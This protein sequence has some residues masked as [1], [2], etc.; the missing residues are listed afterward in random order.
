MSIDLG[1]AIG[2]LDLDTSGFTSGF[3][4]AKK[5][6]KTFSD[7]STTLNDKISASGKIMSTVGGTLT[8]YVTT[9]LLGAGTA[10]IG[11][12]TSVDKAFNQFQGRV[13]D[14]VKD[15][16][17]YRNVMSDIYANNFG[18]SIEDVANSMADVVTYLGEMPVDKMQS[19]TESAITLRNTFGYETAESLRTVDT[20]MKNFGLSAEEAFD[21]IVTGTQEGL[22]F[23]GEF[24]DTINEYSVQFDKLGFSAEDMFAILKQGADSGAWNL[25][26]I[27][28][29][30]KE[31]SIRAVDGSNT[32]IQGFELLGFSAEDM[33]SKFAQGGDTAKT[34]FREIINALADMEDP[35]QQN[36]AGV[37]LFGTM[38]EDLG[39]EV[40]TQLADITD[41]AMVTT[42]AM[43]QLKEVKYDDLGSALEGLWRTFQVLVGELGESLIPKV[44]SVIE[45]LQ[46]LIDKFRGMDDS[47]KET[48]VNVGLFV[49]ALGPVLTI[50]GKLISGVSSLVS[51]ISTAVAAVGGWGAAL[52]ALTGPIGIVIAAVAA[53]AAAWA[54]D[55]AGIRETVQSVMTSIQEIISSVWEAI[56]DLWNNN[57][58]GIQTIAETVW[59]TIQG[60]FESAFGIIESIFGA[61]AAL[62][63]GDWE[64]LWT[65]VQNIAS[66]IWSII[67]GLLE[68]FLDT[69]ISIILGIATRLYNSAKE[70]FNRVKD[71]FT[72]VWN[73]ITSW[74]ESVID[75]PV[76]TIRSIGTDLFNAGRDIFNSLWD[77]LQSVWSSITSWVENAVNWIVDKVAFWKSE[78]SKMNTDVSSGGGTGGGRHAAGLDYVPYTGYRATLEEGERILTKQEAQNYGKTTGVIMNMNITF[79][80]AVDRN[81]ARKVSRQIAKDTV[82]QLRSKGVVLA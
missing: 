33:A 78:A 29:A 77:G 56:T 25:D 75:D 14:A 1:T 52:T 65:E 61:F 47:T 48:I 68:G 72:E 49:A 15:L 19:V 8:K 51:W 44:E 74:F 18:E 55:F 82:A 30:I 50:G 62:F 71:G 46:N 10:A 37:N 3:D 5:Y 43:E 22:D 57:F 76:G 27:G 79:T 26:K 41:A 38:W 70:V 66:N 4:R 64:T 36:I 58:L 31:F 23:S 60:I 67:T 42:G 54:T 63:R 12:A 69:I 20:L 53:F 21:Y 28:D 13:G 7:E 16:G 32:T 9:P 45:F 81:A 34:A 17:Q 80:E 39:P 6:L 24:L 73:T 40:V 2:Y 59:N 11:F 35:V